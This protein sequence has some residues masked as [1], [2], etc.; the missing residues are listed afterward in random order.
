MELK[1][2]PFLILWPLSAGVL[3]RFDRRRFDLISAAMT[4]MALHV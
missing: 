1:G 4:A 2:L 3:R